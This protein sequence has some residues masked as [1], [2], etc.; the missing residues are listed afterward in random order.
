MAINT[1]PNPV[2]VTLEL[3][4][5]VGLYAYYSSRVKRNSEKCQQYSTNP[6]MRATFE[7]DERISRE[8]RERINALLEEHGA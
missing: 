6:R 7:S 1:T 4:D 2:E 8:D 3:R 5:L